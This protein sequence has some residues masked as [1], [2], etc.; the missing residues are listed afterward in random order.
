MGTGL[1]TGHT[2]CAIPPPS[3]ARHS[4][5]HG[6]QFLA[7]HAGQPLL[8]FP[9]RQGPGSP[10]CAPQRPARRHPPTPV[11]EPVA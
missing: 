5:T 4:G 2:F 6:T 10:P 11:R 8:G 9:E 1:P 7:G 3:S